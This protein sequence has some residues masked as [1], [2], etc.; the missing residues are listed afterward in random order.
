MT[1]YLLQHLLEQ[2]TFS[3][4]DKTAVQCG[5]QSISYGPLCEKSTRLANQ[6]AATGF[7]PRH[8]AGIYLPKS[9]EAVISLF[10]V[11]K[12][13]GMYIP[14]DAHYSPFSRIKHIIRE[15]G[16]DHVI[17][18]STLWN[19]F[20]SSL[21]EGESAL[22]AHKKIIFV[23]DLLQADDGVAMERGKR[24]HSIKGRPNLCYYDNSFSAQ[25][26]GTCPVTDDDLAYILYTSGST[27]D[28]K[29]VMLT[30]RNALTFV[31]WALSYFL[32]KSTDVF[33]NIAPLHFDLSVFDIFV[34]IACKGCLQLLPP[35]MGA[36]PRA[37]LSWMREKGITFFYSV[38]SLWIALL[39]YAD[40]RQTGLPSLSHILFAG[41]IFP[42]AQLKAL[43]ELV[44]HAAYYNLYGPTETNVCTCY[45][46]KNKSEVNGRPVPIGSPCANTEVIVIKNDNTEALVNEQGE[47]LVKGSIVCKGYYK[48]PG[49]TK[50]AFRKSPLPHHQGALFY[51]TGDIVRVL[52]PGLYEFVCRKDLMVKCSGFRVEL[53]EIEQALMKH[54][55]IRE[56]VVVPVYDR[57]EVHVLSL[58]A[59]ITTAGP[60][61]IN[62][63]EL[64]KFLAELLPR[65]MIPD[66]ITVYKELPKNANG[67]AGRQQLRELVKTIV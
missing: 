65:Y 2:S 6:L 37:I 58:S 41:E 54:R 36:N 35:A 49:R 40:I 55:D 20:I 62:I 67:K 11:L 30:H 47:L 29:G 17:T 23:D 28:P 31:N 25:P 34:S 51:K 33:S 7:K 16:M 57:E 38:P 24:V 13:G 15:S 39:R 66:T 21:S 44:P 46:V 63:I 52:R 26:P 8:P 27:G 42:P 60:T 43:M 64:K 45:H 12:A 53:Q 22:I 3:C 1:V 48:T 59:F 32:P 18:L 10:A 19:D 14:L 5:P 61:V 56:A 9:I 4:P 50:A